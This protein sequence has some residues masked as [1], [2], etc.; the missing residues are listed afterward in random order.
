VVKSVIGL[1]LACLF[2]VCM[3]LLGGIASGESPYIDLGPMEYPLSP[4]MGWAYVNVE[5]SSPDGSSYLGP[6]GSAVNLVGS[7][8]PHNRL[9]LDTGSNSTLFVA[10]AAAELAARG[11]IQAGSYQDIGVAGPE[12]YKVSA[13]YRYEFWGTDG[14]RHTLSPAGSTQVMYNPDADIGGPIAYSIYSVPGILGM[15]AMT[16]RVTTLDLRP[17]MVQK[18][19]FSVGYMDTVFS[20]TRPT[21]VPHRYSVELRAS[22][23]FSPDPEWTAP[24]WANV[25]FA[26]VR[27]QYG[28]ASATGDFLMDTGANGSILSTRLAASLGLDSNGDGQ[29]G[30]G[31][32]AY[33]GDAQMAGVG[34]TISVPVFALQKFFLPTQQ[35]VELAWG[36]D[37]SPPLVGILDIA[38][39]DGVFGMDMLANTAWQLDLDPSSSAFLAVGNPNLEQ[40]HFDFTDWGAT[41]LGT[42]WLDVSPAL[43]VVVP[44]PATLLLLAI[45]G[46]CVVLRR[47]LG[48]RSI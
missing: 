28:A 14:T 19:L 2:V 9:I 30:E 12:T 33:A 3:P 15:P 38:G 27:A 23:Q 29:F 10:E 8:V 5:L 11:I 16:G 31:D 20:Q 44:E 34:G 24:T 47:M 13:P 1:R 26:T 35:G 7:D 4:D 46:V 48:R 43:D 42:L 40:L 25:P 45:A 37:D 39:L 36:R 17:W 41:G 6:Y 18:D 22:P 21:S 32:D